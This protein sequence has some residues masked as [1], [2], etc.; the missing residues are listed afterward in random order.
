MILWFLDRENS[1]TRDAQFLG[2]KALDLI[3]CSFPLKVEYRSR[4]GKVEQGL[5]AIAERV[6]PALN[7]SRTV[8]KQNLDFCDNFLESL[9]DQCQAGI[10]IRGSILQI[11][12]SIRQCITYRSNGGLAAKSAGNLFPR[13]VDR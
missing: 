6:E 1:E 7:V 12:P 2:P 4:K 9:A 5:L 10:G 8:R 11:A 3:G 13:V